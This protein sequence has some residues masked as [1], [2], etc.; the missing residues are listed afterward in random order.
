MYCQKHKIARYFKTLPAISK[1]QSLLLEKRAQR[2]QDTKP[3]S[4]FLTLCVFEALCE[5]KIRHAA[6]TLYLFRKNA[7][8]QTG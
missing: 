7:P 6:E 4:D 8:I 3:L 5:N 1:Y 2:H